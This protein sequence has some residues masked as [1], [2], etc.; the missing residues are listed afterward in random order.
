MFICAVN[1]THFKQMALCFVKYFSINSRIFS[2][3]T[4]NVHTYFIFNGLRHFCQMHPFSIWINSVL[5]Y[6][7][8]RQ[9][10][11]FNIFISSDNEIFTNLYY[12]IQYNIVCYYTKNFEKWT[13][14]TI[15]PISIS[16]KLSNYL[17]K[18]INY[19]NINIKFYP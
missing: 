12:Y 7:K 18:N 2:P 15:F 9:F 4:L 5:L 11:L 14:Q 6:T 1:R 8:F 10:K 17:Q 16:P 3:L 13:C 19:L